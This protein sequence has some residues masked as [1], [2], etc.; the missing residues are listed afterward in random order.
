M[1]L[2]DFLKGPDINEGVQEC[3]KTEGSI[4]VDV[5]EKDEFEEG[6]IPSAVNIPLSNITT[7]T[8]ILSNKETPLFVYCLSGARS[9]QAESIFK[10]LGYSTVKN[11]G[12]MNRYQG[13]IDKN[14]RK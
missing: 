9:K 13:P 5:R 10:K 6:H 12:G 11:I 3:S 14:T 8:S 4:L 2:L 7:I 1:G